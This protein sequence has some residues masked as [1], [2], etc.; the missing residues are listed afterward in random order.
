MNDKTPPSIKQV[1]QPLSESESEKGLRKNERAVRRDPQSV[2]G[3]WLVTA[4]K[5]MFV[6]AL[7][8]ERINNAGLEPARLTAEE[9]AHKTVRTRKEKLKISRKD[10]ETE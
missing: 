1:S 3:L 2:Q 9:S 10:Q 8:R 5:R 7:S 6:I 4:S